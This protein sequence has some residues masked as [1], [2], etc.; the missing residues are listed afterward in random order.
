MIGGIFINA[1]DVQ[2]LLGCERYATAH[3]YLTGVKDSLGKNS[4]YITIKEFCKY[5]ELDFEYV[6]KL[7]RADIDINNLNP[8][9][10][11]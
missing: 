1:N 8:K 10:R 11:I 6:W 9:K 5:E 4:K 7:L 3:K 2:K